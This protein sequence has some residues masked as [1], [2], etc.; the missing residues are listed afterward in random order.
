MRGGDLCTVS[1]CINVMRMQWTYERRVNFAAEDAGVYNWGKRA[2]R[3]R[4]I[5]VLYV[6]IRRDYPW[7]SHLSSHFAVFAWHDRKSEREDEL[8]PGG[9]QTREIDYTTAAL[10]SERQGY[11][12]CGRAAVGVAIAP[13]DERTHLAH[14][15]SVAHMR[16]Q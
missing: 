13:A 10:A 15:D 1:V 3:R 9:A 7:P 6:I 4:C 14:H 2:V 16:M 5:G 11:C 12:S 8:Y